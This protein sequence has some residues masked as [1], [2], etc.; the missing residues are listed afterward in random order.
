MFVKG[1]SQDQTKAGTSRVKP[2]WISHAW[3]ECP[4]SAELGEGDRSAT[5]APRGLR[6]KET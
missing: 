4:P 2:E 5:G 6:R 1:T 3:H